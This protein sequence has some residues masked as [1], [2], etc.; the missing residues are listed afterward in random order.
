MI[1]ARARARQAVRALRH[2]VALLRNGL[3]EAPRVYLSASRIAE[4]PTWRT[5][6]SDPPTRY[7]AYPLARI[8]HWFGAAPRVLR[9][10]FVV[11]V[12]HVLAMARDIGDWQ[13]GLRSLDR[14]NRDIAACECRVVLTVTEGTVEHSK[15]YVRPELWEKLDYVYPAY[16]A[17]DVRPAAARPFTI[18]SIASRWSDK[19]MPE[20]L[21]AYAA[22][23]QRFGND[24]RMTIVAS[25]V[26]DNTVLSKDINVIEV[27][28]MDVAM[29]ERI[30]R[31]ADLLLLPC[32]SDTAACFPEAY[33]FGVPVISTRIQHGDEFVRDGRTGYLV[34]P[35][36]FV[37]SDDYGRRWTSWQEF[38][39]DVE[40][41]RARGEL[42]AV[43][44][45]MIDGAT[46][47]ILDR[48]LHARMSSEARQFHR[49]CFSIEARNEKLRRI[50]CRVAGM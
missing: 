38:Q 6:Q 32:Y 31:S 43:T 7:V 2:N 37:Y 44:E 14:I 11:E 39:A 33:A 21:D 35:P 40:R 19:G 41:V 1:H 8:G 50:Y 24:V 27:A 17:Q 22:L 25:K 49:E 13:R 46:R 10:P 28:R 12:E 26:P 34:D 3:G 42:R 23:R 15:R 48:C 16:P 36:V 30:F 5:Y 20:V 47:L 29:K 45:A 9:K 4:H 18:A